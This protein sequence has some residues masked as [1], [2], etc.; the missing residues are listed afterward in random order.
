MSPLFLPK[1]LLH[2]IINNVLPITDGAMRDVLTNLL[3]RK[4]FEEEFPSEVYLE[5]RQRAKMRMESLDKG[6][7]GIGFVDTLRN[8]NDPIS[9]ELIK[10]WNEIDTNNP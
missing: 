3:E 4:T 5:A 7:N 8:G 1:H 2:A 6:R 9:E 10:W